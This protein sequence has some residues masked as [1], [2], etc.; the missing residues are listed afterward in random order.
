MADQD[1]K[2]T[3]AEISQHVLRKNNYDGEASHA[4]LYQ[5]MRREEAGKIVYM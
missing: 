2:L 1:R 4:E 3:M 5:I